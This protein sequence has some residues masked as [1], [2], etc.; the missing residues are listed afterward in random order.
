MI[1][2]E[3]YRIHVIFSASCDIPFCCSSDFCSR[4]FEEPMLVLEKMSSKSST[5]ETHVTASSVTEAVGKLR[6]QVRLGSQKRCGITMRAQY[7]Q[8]HKMKYFAGPFSW[9]ALSF[10]LWF[11]KLRYATGHYSHQKQF[12]CLLER[13]IIMETLHDNFS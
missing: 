12:T 10:E 11:P 3:Y 9:G 5:T 2:I 4:E 7:S 13:E 8:K 6:N 1:N